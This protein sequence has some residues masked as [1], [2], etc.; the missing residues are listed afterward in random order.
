MHMAATTAP[1][2]MSC[3]LPDSVYF[4]EGL[5]LHRRSFKTTAICDFLVK[6]MW[7]ALTLGYGTD[8][9]YGPMKTSYLTRK[10]L[11]LINL[12]SV[13]ARKAINNSHPRLVNLMDPDMQYS[14]GKANANA[15][16]ALQ[17]IYQNVYDGTFINSEDINIH[18]DL[19]GATEIVLWGPKSTLLRLK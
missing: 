8:E 11:R 19:E 1:A 7:F 9:T 16:K 3:E 14:G 6:P 5:T 12:G 18:E 10:T 2:T 15:H 4:E 17:E 13:E